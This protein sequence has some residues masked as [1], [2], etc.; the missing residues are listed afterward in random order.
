MAGHRAF[1]LVLLVGACASTPPASPERL[2]EC[3]RL[4]NTWARYEQHWVFHHDGH[5]AK[6]ELA[7]YRC[8]QGRYDEGIAELKGLLRRGRFTIPD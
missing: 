3:M 2:A 6:A 1:M 8:Q 5:K 7:L 4:F